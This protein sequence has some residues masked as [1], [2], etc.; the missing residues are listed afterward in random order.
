M[1]GLRISP[2][3]FIENGSTQRQ[4]VVVGTLRQVAEGAMEVE[5]PAVMVAGAVVTLRDELISAVHE[6]CAAC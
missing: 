2:S 5:A 1:G 3:P 4:R 6:L